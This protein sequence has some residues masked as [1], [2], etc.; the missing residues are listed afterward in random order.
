MISYGPKLVGKRAFARWIE[1]AGRTQ[2]LDLS[3]AGKWQFKHNPGSQFVSAQALTSKLFAAY[4]GEDSVDAI[5]PDHSVPSVHSYVPYYR[6]YTSTLIHN[7]FKINYGIKDPV[8]FRLSIF[9][10]REVF[11]TQQFLLPGDG[12]SFIEDPARRITALPQTGTLVVEA[13]HSRIATPAS[14]LRFF[15]LYRDEGNRLVS[16]VHSMP[17]KSASGWHALGQPS[18][19]GFGEAR[20]AYE[21]CHAVSP[22][23]P[24]MPT[25]GERLLRKLRCQNP[26]PMGGFI[27]G[28]SA[29]AGPASVWHDGTTPQRLSVATNT[30]SVGKSYTSFHIP[31]FEHHAPY[32]LVSS[33]EVGFQPRSATIRIVPEGADAAAEQSISID[34]D[35]FTIDLSE[36]FANTKLTGPVNVAVEFDRDIGDFTELPQNMLHVYFRSPAGLADQA[37]SYNSLGYFDDP[38][39]KKRSYRCRKF[40]PY[41]SDPNLQFTYSIMN[42]GS[43]G[44]SLRDSTVRI[45]IYTD[46][47]SEHLML[48]KLSPALITNMPAEEILG[49]SGANIHNAAVILIEHDTINFAGSW[50][51][52][53]RNSGHLA[54]DHFTGG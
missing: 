49:S 50:Y 6:G 33:A 37:A 1:S 4:Y 5:V 25:A 16:G 31:R 38:F 9:C 47:G 41:V 44:K 26:V 48:R 42:L 27:V 18:Y 53:D 12:V 3:K 2:E 21:Y 36:L 34:Y 19:R 13:F 32:V 51:V 23:A 39:R 29:N 7:F 54:V 30:R 14:Q 15:V 10:E 22:P 45:R 24:L 8:L 35:N 40:A 28:K 11:W 52:A 17:V 43:D 46:S 20:G